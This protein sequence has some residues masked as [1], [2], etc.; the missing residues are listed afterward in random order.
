MAVLLFN[1]RWF[2]DERGWFSETFSEKRFLPHAPNVTFRQDNRSF[3]SSPG[4][5]RGLH[6]QTPPHAQGKLVWCTRGAIFD[7]AVDLRRGSPT[8]GHSVSVELSAENGR[9]IFIPSGFAHGL[10]TLQPD[11]EVY[12]KVTDFYAPENDTGLLWNDPTLNIA[13]PAPAAAPFLS[14]KDAALPSFKNFMSPFAYDG[15]PLSLIEVN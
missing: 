6:F 5:V 1:I 4:T 15:T 3:S 11:T 13:W 14:P 9:Q 10:M 2:E 12:Y 8:Y 7:V